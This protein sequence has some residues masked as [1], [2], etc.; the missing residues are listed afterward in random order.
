MKEAKFEKIVEKYKKG[1]STLSE[2]SFL[3]N[4]AKNS[5][6]SLEAWSTFIKKNKTEAPKDLNE[7]LWQSFQT[8]KAKK[9]RLFVKI[10][11]AAASIILLVSFFFGNLEKEEQSYSEKERLLN[12]ALAMFD[13]NEEEDI[14][15]TIFYENEMIIVYLTIEKSNQKIENH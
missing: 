9:R 11:G 15:H 5:G 8:K 1:E 3:F 2:E 10:M 6:P 12:Q 13:S 14:Q 7:R 4:N